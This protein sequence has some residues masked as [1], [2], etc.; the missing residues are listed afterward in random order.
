MLGSGH[1]ASFPATVYAALFTVAPTSVGGG[2]EVT[3]GSYA[4]VAITNNTTN[5]PAASGGVKSN[6]TAIVFPAATASWGTVVFCAL[7]DAAV[8]GN[9]VCGGDL[10][11][12]RVVPS[13][14][15][16]QIL[17]G[18]LTLTPT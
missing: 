7:F 17:A 1:G 8:A 12:N 11:Q 16:A 2:T 6:G 18:Q 5:W 10:T 14:D 4:R 3:G 13:G 15:T 9:L